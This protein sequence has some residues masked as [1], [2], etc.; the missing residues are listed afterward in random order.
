MSDH[1]RIKRIPDKDKKCRFRKKELSNLLEIL[2]DQDKPNKFIP[3][4]GLYGIGKSTLAKNLLN[5]VADR[6][7]FTGGIVYVQM[8]DMRSTITVL[9]LI[10]REILTSIKL[11][12]REK[13]K[14]EHQNSENETKLIEFIVSIINNQHDLKLEKRH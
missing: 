5:F 8:K 6:N 1:I 14:L 7:Y 10:K 4:L 11:D 12:S 2:M 9:K 3:V 13:Q